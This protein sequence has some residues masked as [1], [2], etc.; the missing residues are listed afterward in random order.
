MAARA[1]VIAI[2]DYGAGNF[3]PPLPGCN[4]DAESFIRWLLEKKMPNVKRESVPDFIRCCSG[5]DI[6][7]G[8]DL[9]WRA[10]GTTSDE[11]LEELAACMEL[12]ADRTDEFYFFFSGHGFSY[13]NNTWEKSVD[14]LVGSNFKNLATGGR[15]CLSL[16]EDR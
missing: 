16:D 8:K 5:K 7:E 11:I 4:R 6:T 1:F 13:S 2:E 3:L 12:W 10:A 15:A 14:V 9:E